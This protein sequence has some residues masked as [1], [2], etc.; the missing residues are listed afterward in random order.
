MKLKHS[1][2]AGATLGLVAVA[3]PALATG[4]ASTVAVGGNSTAGQSPVT[5]TS[6]GPL[7]FQAEK[8]DGT[9]LTMN[10]E[11]GNVPASPASYVN[12]GTGIVDIATLNRINLVR[13]TGPGGG[14]TVTM[15]PSQ[16]LHR[17]GAVTAGATDVIAGHIDGV[18][19]TASNAVCRFTVTGGADGTFNEGNQKLTIN[20]TANGTGAALTVS[21]VTGCLG[22]VKNG[23]KAKF[24]GTFTTTTSGGAVNVKP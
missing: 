23:G 17:T 13:C 2:V 12:R 21:G 7:T 24:S 19:A 22:Q 5:A 1:L 9:F 14:L 4:S 10:C 6:D 15:A 8:P 20:E 3:G 16:K 11:S 18:K